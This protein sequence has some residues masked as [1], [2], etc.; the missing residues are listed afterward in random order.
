MIQMEVQKLNMC[1]SG[2]VFGHLSPS[3]VCF[4]LYLIIL[5]IPLKLI[6]SYSWQLFY[7]KEH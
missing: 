6:N 3:L 2:K 4:A 5:Y 7:I 1:Y